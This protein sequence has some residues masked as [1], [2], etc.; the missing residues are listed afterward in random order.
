MLFITE[1]EC[2]DILLDST[3]GASIAHNGWYKRNLFGIWRLDVTK[4]REENVYKKEGTNYYIHNLGNKWRVSSCKKR[5]FVILIQSS[6]G[7]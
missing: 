5:Y 4:Y 2:R 7:V 1:K 6:L 3:G